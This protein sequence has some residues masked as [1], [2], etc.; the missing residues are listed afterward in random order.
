M[1]PPIA[2]F[3]QMETLRVKLILPENTPSQAAREAFDELSAVHEDQAVFQ[4]N[5]TEYVDEDSWG[6]SVTHTLRGP[7]DRE[8]VQTAS[9]VDIER[10]MARAA[11][12]PFDKR[13]ID[14]LEQPDLDSRSE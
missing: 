12:A 7:E 2:S 14:D 8:F 4:L 11:A 13:V 5:Q 10:A 1:T 6:F 9:L 3:A